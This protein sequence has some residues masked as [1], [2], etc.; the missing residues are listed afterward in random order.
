M[1]IN[2]LVYHPPPWDFTWRQKKGVENWDEKS[3]KSEKE[4]KK[5]SEKK[6]RSEKSEIPGGGMVDQQVEQHIT[7][8]W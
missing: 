5:W 2:L 4:V 7:L 6:F 1:L 3:E 8:Y